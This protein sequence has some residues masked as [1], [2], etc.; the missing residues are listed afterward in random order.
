MNV[1]GGFFLKAEQWPRSF[2]ILKKQVLFI[3]S[4]SGRS[5]DGERSRQG[6]PVRAASSGTLTC[7]QS[8]SPSSLLSGCCSRENGLR[9]LGQPDLLTSEQQESEG[10]RVSPRWLLAAA[11]TPSLCLLIKFWFHEMLHSR[12]SSWSSAH[13]IEEA[14]PSSLWFS[15]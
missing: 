11:Q 13:L 4:Q 3:C 5:T 1:D 12:A 14:A 2:L 15:L 6:E 9:L 8:S 7:R 10:R